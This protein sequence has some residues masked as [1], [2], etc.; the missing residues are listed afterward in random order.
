MVVDLKDV[1]PFL[2]WLLPAL[3]NGWSVLAC[4]MRCGDG[5]RLAAGGRAAR[6]GGG[7]ANHVAACYANTVVDLVRLSPRRIWALA[8]LAIQES[9]RRRVVVVFAVFIVILLFAGW[10]LDPESI[11]PARLY[12]DFV[13][14]ATSYLVLLLALFLSSLSLPAD[15]KNRTLYTVVTKPVR[16]SEVVLGRIVGFAA[17][18]TL[19]LLVDGRDQLRLRRARPGPYPRA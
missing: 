10:Y 14:T 19:L 9:I 11:D 1:V 15:I 7:H 2:T 17:V 13:L 5:R 12:L 18:T 6:P 16:A 8:R 4:V 3:S